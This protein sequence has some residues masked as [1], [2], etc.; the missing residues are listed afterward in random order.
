M[1]PECTLIAY[2]H[3]KPEKRE[4]LL[5]I[6]RGFVGPTREEVGC[7]DY[8]LHVSDDDPNLFVFYENWRTRKDLDEHL[9]QPLLASFWPTR[10]DYLT[11]DVEMK[12][13][14]MLTDWD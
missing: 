2:L 5:E 14:T 9:A 7:V 11:K 8:H 6:L 12:F 1:R 4:E 13:L 10:L 3:V